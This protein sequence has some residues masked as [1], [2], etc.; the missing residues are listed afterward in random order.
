MSHALHRHGRGIANG[1][2]GVT[3]RQATDCGEL[4]SALEGGE[5]EEMERQGLS[6]TEQ[7]GLAVGVLVLLIGGAVAAGG[8]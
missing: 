8:G 3:H 5:E 6:R 4:V 1:F 2:H 7:L